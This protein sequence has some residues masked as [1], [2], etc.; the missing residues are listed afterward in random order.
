MVTNRIYICARQRDH[1]LQASSSTGNGLALIDRFI[2][3][4]LRRKLI[5]SLTPVNVHI[6]FRF[7][8]FGKSVSSSVSRMMQCVSLDFLRISHYSSVS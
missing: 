4:G 1:S 2:V 7:Q 6:I 8:V 5:L 3:T